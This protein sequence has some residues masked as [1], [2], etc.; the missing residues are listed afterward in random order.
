M[1]NKHP[2]QIL[3]SSK[4]VTPLTIAVVLFLSV[5]VAGIFIYGFSYSSFLNLFNDNAHLIVATI[6]VFFVILIGGIDISVGSMMAFVG[7]STA[8]MLREGMPSFF[9]I[10]MM[11]AF[12]MLFGTLQGYLVVIYRLQPFIVTL[13]GLFF[14]RALCSIVSRSAIAIQNPFFLQ[15]A[16]AKAQINIGGIRGKIYYYALIPFLIVI[17]V[18]LILRYTKTGRNF[19]AI[20]GN[21]QSAILMGLPA[22]RTRI[23]AYSISGFCAAI[24]GILFSFYTLAGYSLQNVGLELEA[25]SSAVIGGALLTGGVG[26]VFGVTIGSLMQGLIQTIVTYQNLNAWWTKVAIA[27]LLCFFIVIQKMIAVNTRKIRK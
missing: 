4:H 27:L 5:F 19:Y 17:F 12:G 25:I 1:H 9:V 23:L 24:A 20:G 26:S 2:I 7:V 14:L 11:L 16:L 18:F 15:V 21:Q 13:A 8:Y 3:L 10:V 22:K 6:G